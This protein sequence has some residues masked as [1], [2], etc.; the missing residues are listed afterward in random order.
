MIVYLVVDNNFDNLAILVP[1][2]DWTTIFEIDI[3]DVH[4]TATNA[5]IIVITTHKATIAAITTS[6]G[7]VSTAFSTAAKRVCRG[8]CS[9]CCVFITLGEAVLGGFDTATSV[10]DVVG[11]MGS[12]V[13]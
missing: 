5:T 11:M 10:G 3:V 13:G 8:S 2:D 9:G 7:A 6:V 4:I 1:L 12:I